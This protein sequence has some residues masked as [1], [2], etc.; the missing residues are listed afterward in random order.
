MTVKCDKA[1][2]WLA[3]L[4]AV[5]ADL[6]GE[7]ASPFAAH[8]AACP[9]CRA[10]LQRY[11]AFVSY[12]RAFLEQGPSDQ[13]EKRFIAAARA[14]GNKDEQSPVLADEAQG[15]LLH[16]PSVEAEERFLDAARRQQATSA[17]SSRR[18][19]LWSSVAAA[20]AIAILAIGLWGL[21]LTV[22]TGEPAQTARTIAV[23]EQIG[24][25]LVNDEPLPIAGQRIVTVG[26]TIATAGDS[27]LR[28][29]DER[30]AVVTIMPE[31]S[32]ELQ[33]WS[34]HVTTLVL[35]RGTVLA[36]VAHRNPDEHFEVL[37]ENVR[38]SVV[39]TEFSVHCEG[40]G[41]TVVATLSGRVRVERADGLLIGFVTAGETLRVESDAMIAQRSAQTIHS[42]GPAVDDEPI[43][44]SMIEE[45]SEAPEEP[46][47]GREF[48]VDAAE[49]LEVLT[50][51]TVPLPVLVPKELFGDVGP[52]EAAAKTPSTASAMQDEG[53]PVEKSAM[54]PSEEISSTADSLSQARAML[55]R[56]ETKRA[57]GMLRELESRDW[58]RHALLGD[59][60]QLE[61]RYD[62]AERA[63][64]DSLALAPS[65]SQATLLAEL[66]T[67]QETRLKDIPSAVKSWLRYL[68]VSPGGAEVVRAHLC[69]GRN[70]LGKGRE[71]QVRHHLEVL[72]QEFP[73][74]A[75]TVSLLATYGAHLLAGEQWTQAEALF[76]PL[77]TGGPDPLAE[78]ALVGLIRVRIAQGDY[79]A[80]KQ[81]IGAYRARYRNGHRSGEVRRLEEAVLKQ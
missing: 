74:A 38:V 68:D 40:D 44:S 80:A 20:A 60:H 16:R 41:E 30:N 66:A 56:G 27:Q 11:E 69:I 39:G 65:D 67:L 15:L 78:T 57:L 59:A 8:F 54:P 71:Q 12:C 28:I 31:T 49:S 18:R 75:E 36:K 81:L 62:A 37:T 24:T 5:S 1:R 21:N 2:R 26:A 13:A 70:A 63:Y 51:P 23:V 9:S 76:E 14:M 22:R 6:V 52:A 25:V 17:P 50:S 46:P 32:I 47:V 64:L 3:E 35:S 48:F 43:A 72:L 53:R 42:P 33:D 73:A 55:A 79:V 45:P 7:N 58:R 29:G 61:G 34:S 10:L 77:S 4:S 19:I